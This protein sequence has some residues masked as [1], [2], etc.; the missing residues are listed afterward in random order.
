MTTTNYYINYNFLLKF[1]LS[2]TLVGVLLRSIARTPIALLEYFLIFGLLVISI[3]YIIENLSVNRKPMI[4]FYLF[5]LYLLIHTLTV[6]ITRIIDLD[7]PFFQ[8]LFYSLY[9]FRL[10]TLAY[11]LVLLFVPIQ[12]ENNKKFEKFFYLLLKISIFYTLFEQI[13]SL[14]GFRGFFETFYSNAGVVQDLGGNLGLKHFGLYRVWGVIG[15]PQLLGVF[16]IITMLYM[17]NKKDKPWTFLSFLA[18]IVS[19]SKT[20]YFILLFLALIY[21]IQKK[22][23]LTLLVTIFLFFLISVGVGQFYLYLM[24]VGDPSVYDDYH[25]FINFIGSIQGYYLLLFY[26]YELGSIGESVFIEG[27]PLVRFTNYFLENPLEIFF[28][29]GLTYSFLA[30]QGTA[31]AG[32][33]ASPHSGDP[34]ASYERLTSDFYVLS[35]VFQYG[36]IGAILLFYVFFYYPFTKLLTSHGY[37]YYIPITL[38]ISMFHYS[39]LISKLIMIVAAYAMC[40]IYLESKSTHEKQH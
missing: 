30:L 40:S 6:T 23:Y 35:Y 37:Y 34:F 2:F 31:D 9:E 36:I 20:A 22:Y 24:E 3:I 39:P 29:K 7:A 15:S 18:I 8:T 13:F 4:L 32:A 5:L 12:L 26:K 28:G 21:L 38:F 17:L 25:G 33:N 14:I 19:T 11:F 1:T 10:S 27:G 16:H